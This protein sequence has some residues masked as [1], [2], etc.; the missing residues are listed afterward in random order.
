MNPHFTFNALESISSF[1]MEQKPREAVQYLNRFARLMRYTLE[2][3]DQERVPLHDELG[4]LAHYIALEQMRFDQ[5]FDFVSEVDESLDASELSV[6]PMLLQPL[7][8]NAIL[9]GLR[10]L[11]GRR[12]CLTLRVLQSVEPDRIR[13]EV[14]DNGIGRVAASAQRTGDEGHKR[15]MATRILENRLKALAEASGKAYTL[16]VEDLN[17]GTRVILA[18]PKDEVWGA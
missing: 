10:P 7:V 18:L 11:Q 6:P 16:S 3:A 12:G 9:H 17:E 5:S 2:K 14:E 4:A 13:I 8:E 1:V 15:S